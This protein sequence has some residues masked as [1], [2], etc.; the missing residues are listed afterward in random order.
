M[1]CDTAVLCREIFIKFPRIIV[2]MNEMN[3]RISL[4]GSASWMDMMAAKVAS[5]FEGLLDW[6]VGEIL[7]SEG[8]N[9]TLGDE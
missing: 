7:V 2:P 5:K 1:P 3:L 6:Q 9:F 4:W 8:D